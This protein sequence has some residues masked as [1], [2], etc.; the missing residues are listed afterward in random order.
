MRKKVSLTFTTKTQSII[1]VGKVN[2][3]LVMLLVDKLWPRS[4]R[5][6]IKGG[7]DSN[8]L[9]AIKLIMGI[10]CKWRNWDDEYCQYSASC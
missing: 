4:K 10:A 8:P 5:F 1:L 3:K 9:F 2:I 7:A 6:I